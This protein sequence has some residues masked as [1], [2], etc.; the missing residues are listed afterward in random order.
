MIR[1]ELMG[2]EK[3]GEWDALVEHPL[4]S[5]AWGKFREKRQKVTKLARIEDG[6]IVRIWLIIWT[7]VPGVNRCFGYIPMGGLCDQRDIKEL[8]KIG[9]T[10]KA[11]GIRMEPNLGIGN[12]KIFEDLNLYKGRNLFKQK[13]YIWNLQLSEEKLLANMHQKA[14]YNI[15]VADKHGV[16]VEENNQAINDYIEML[17]EGTVKRQKVGMHDKTY[18]INM[19]EILNNLGVAKMFTAKYKGQILSIVIIYLWKNKI[20]YAY[21]ANSL[22]H[23]EVMAATKLIWEV[24]K[25]AKKSGYDYFDLWGTEE[26]K[27]FGRFKEQFGAELVTQVGSFDLAV[28]RIEYL[29]FRIVEEIRWRI[30]HR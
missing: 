18:Q 9:K 28:N 2:D 27:G 23:K 14:R 22:I 30:R 10:N 12:K 24:A 5:V 19:F 7:R 26:G 3:N 11:I 4:Q 17:F 16:E 29:L 25:W 15:K 1:Y 6:V 21:G 13:T 20:Y 8:I